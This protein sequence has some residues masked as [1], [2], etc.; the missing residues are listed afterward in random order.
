MFVF[1]SVS[2]RNIIE[3]I[4]RLGL[5]WL[6]LSLDVFRFEFGFRIGVSLGL[7]LV[8]IR[9]RCAFSL[10]RIWLQFG[11]DMFCVGFGF[12]FS[13]LGLVSI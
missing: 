1:N 7:C 4:S 8:C 6:G 9:F 3:V 10:G 12:G 13:S 5:V 11:L 2:S